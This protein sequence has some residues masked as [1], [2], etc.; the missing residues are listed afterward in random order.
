MHNAGIQNRPGVLCLSLFAP[1]CS[2]HF[3]RDFHKSGLTRRRGD[4]PYIKNTISLSQGSDGLTAVS[5]E[6]THPSSL[7]VLPLFLPAPCPV[8]AHSSGMFSSSVLGHGEPD[9]IY[10]PLLV[11]KSPLATRTRLRQG[12]VWQI[13]SYKHSKYVC[14]SFYT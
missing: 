4:R 8:W 11:L 1:T 14:H 2:S 12:K 7:V 13:S 10:F 3:L 6:R 9:G 5:I